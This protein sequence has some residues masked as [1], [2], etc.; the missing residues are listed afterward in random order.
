MGIAFEEGPRNEHRY[1][2]GTAGN[3]PATEPA[4]GT[5]TVFE[6][7]VANRSRR[8][9]SI[10]ARTRDRAANADGSLEGI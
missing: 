8:T 6:P 2:A 4:D 5:R 1:V 7:S 10:S 9:G 3:V